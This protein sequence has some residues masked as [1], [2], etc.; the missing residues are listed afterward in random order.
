MYEFVEGNP[1]ISFS[2]LGNGLPIIFL[3]GIGGNSSNWE[4]QQIYFS[5]NYTTIAW[6]ARGYLYSDY[7]NGPLNFSDFSEESKPFRRIPL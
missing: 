3:H 5:K 6:N 2:R 1:R 4:E 7:Y